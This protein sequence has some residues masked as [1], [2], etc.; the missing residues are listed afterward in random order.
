ME[1]QFRKLSIILLYQKQKHSKEKI[2][3]WSGDLR[4]KIYKKEPF[5]LA[6]VLAIIIL[7]LFIYFAEI[8]TKALYSSWI[9]KINVIKNTSQAETMG[10]Q[11]NNIVISQS[12]SQSQT[13]VEHEYPEFDHRSQLEHDLAKIQKQGLKQVLDFLTTKARKSPRTARMYY[14]GLENLSNWRDSN[15]FISSDE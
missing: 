8:K 4:Y 9:I 13:H 2:N 3:V 15:W 6:W 14:H 7:D 12:Q 11:R 5:S 10:K 1:N